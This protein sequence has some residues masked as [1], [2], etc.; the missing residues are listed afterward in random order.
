MAQRQEPHIEAR[1]PPLAPLM[2]RCGSRALFHTSLEGVAAE[3]PDEAKLQARTRWIARRF[4]RK[5]PT[6]PERIRCELWADGSVEPGAQPGAAEM[7]YLNGEPTAQ[8]KS[9]ARPMARTS[10]AASIVSQVGLQKLL[11]T[12]PCRNN[13]PCRVL[14]F[15]GPLALPMALQTGPLTATYTILRTLWNLL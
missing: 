11:D 2:L 4:R 12:I 5:G 6:P 13:R 10:R 9:G 8:A 7:I 3:G 1:V 14:V 15:A